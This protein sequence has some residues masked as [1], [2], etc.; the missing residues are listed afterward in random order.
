MRRRKLALNQ[1]AMATLL[2]VYALVNLARGP[3]ASGLAEVK[4]QL[5]GLDP[6]TIDMVENLS[7]SLEKLVY[8]A[9]IAIAVLVQGGTALF[10]LS[11]KKYVERYVADVP[12]WARSLAR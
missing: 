12:E 1:L 9:L 2:I 11:R 10:Y 4:R 5:G 8:G 6:A 3:D 7:N